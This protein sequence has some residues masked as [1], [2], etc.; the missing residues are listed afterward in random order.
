M[1][2][3][4]TNFP[5]HFFPTKYKTI[6]TIIGNHVQFLVHFD[7]FLP[8]Q[9]STELK[10]TIVHSFHSGCSTSHYNEKIV[11]KPI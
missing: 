2:L 8:Q 5:T 11:D 6:K 3:K 7:P 10:K 1:Y 9:T 4:K